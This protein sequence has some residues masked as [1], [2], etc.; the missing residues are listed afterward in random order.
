MGASVAKPIPF[1]FS[2]TPHE[3]CMCSTNANCD[4]PLYFC[5]ADRQAVYQRSS[6][7]HSN[8][9]NTQVDIQHAQILGAIVNFRYQSSSCLPCSTQS[10]VV[11][12]Y[13]GQPVGTIQYDP[14]CCG[15]SGRRGGAHAF[16]ATGKLRYSRQESSCLCCCDGGSYDDCCPC[17]FR[18]KSWP[19]ADPHG[20]KVGEFRFRQH[21]WNPKAYGM[22]AGYRHWPAGADTNQED[23][24]LLMGLALM[25]WI[26]MGKTMEMANG[27][28][29]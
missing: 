4:Y 6:L 10:M 18:E 2:N 26:H 15:G 11:E 21:A 24:L 19:I 16:D 14:K 12:K 3:D 29:K 25:H 7:Y 23:Q 17:G 27:R 20:L 13:G 1:G 22:W 5:T 9:C 28:F 8:C